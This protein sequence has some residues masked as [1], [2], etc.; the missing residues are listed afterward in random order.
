MKRIRV[1]GENLAL[2]S[3]QLLD[4]GFRHG[5]SLRTG[6]VSQGAYAALN[7]GRAV[8]DEP[9][10]VAANLTLF[11]DAIAVAPDLIYEATQVH[12]AAVH[13]LQAHDVLL[14]V[15]KI[16]ADALISFNSQRAVAVRVADCV[17]L[18]LADLSSGMVAAVHAGWRG[19]VAAILPKVITLMAEL[20]ASVH[21]LHI[22]MG[23]HIR[24]CCFEVGDEVAEKLISS[25]PNVPVATR[26]HAKTM[27][28]MSRILYHQLQ[29]IGVSSNQIETLAGCTKCEASRFF[30]FRRDGGKS[31]RHMAAIA[32]RGPVVL[33]GGRLSSMKV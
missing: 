29:T 14:D 26:I 25:A 21:D 5:F 24:S 8:G 18:L 13:V 28:D 9:H 17:P 7:L 27:V 3:K 31:G 2:K 4:A 11:A 6:G 16:Q 23:P 30:S 32:P 22:V 1:R 33:T 20:G 15:R 12:G 19:V 10:A